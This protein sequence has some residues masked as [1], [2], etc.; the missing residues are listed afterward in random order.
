VTGAKRH[1]VS[2]LE[3]VL[4]AIVVERPNPPMRRSKYLCADAGDTGAPALEVVENHGYILHII[5]NIPQ[6]H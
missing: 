2:Q 4:D 5:D 3:A 1:D 6:I